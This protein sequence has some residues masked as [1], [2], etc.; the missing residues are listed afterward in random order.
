MATVM[1]LIGLLK[2]LIKLLQIEK[3]ALINNDGNKVAEIVEKK[4]EYIEKLKEFKG[5]EAA[6][7]E[8]VLSLVEEIN[9]LQETN[10]LLTK[11]AIGYQEM[12]MESIAKNLKNVSNTYTSKGGY[13]KSSNINFI[14][15]SV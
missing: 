12:L 8:K 5:I 7:N 2:S 11:Q 1:E 9:S 3:D 10:L 14:D 15:Q 6:N 4:N 13:E